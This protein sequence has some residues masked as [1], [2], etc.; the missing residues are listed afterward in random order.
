MLEFYAGKFNSTESNYTFRRMPTKE[1]LERWRMRTPATFCFSLKAPQQVTHIRRLRGCEPVIM[2]FWEAAEALQKKLG[3]V[4]F[5]LPPTMSKDTPLLADF[6]AVLPAKMRAAFEFR[7]ASWFSDDVYEVLRQHSAALCIADSEKL[8]TPVVYTSS[9]AYYRLRDEGY[10]PRDITR[11]N[12]MIEA[13]PQR[14]KQ[15][16]VYF[17]HEEKGLGPKFAQELMRRV[18]V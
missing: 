5:Q 16:F 10:E 8:H 11:W 3:A 7:H 12:Q 15:T 13:Q 17:K 9:F 4:L 1:T 2:R 14:I 18:N 6:L